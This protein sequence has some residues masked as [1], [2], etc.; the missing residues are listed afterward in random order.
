MKVLEGKNKSFMR[1]PWWIGYFKRSDRLEKHSDR[2]KK[3][4]DKI[5]KLWDGICGLI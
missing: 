5:W 3:D 2:F 4:N 1:L